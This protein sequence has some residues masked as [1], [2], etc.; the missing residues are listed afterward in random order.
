MTFINT[1]YELLFEFLMWNVIVI[2]SYPLHIIVSYECKC[3]LYKCSNHVHHK[4]RYN[5]I[6]MYMNFC[7][8]FDNCIFV[9]KIHKM[10]DTWARMNQQPPVHQLAVLSIGWAIFSH[11]VS[12]GIHHNPFF[13]TINHCIYLFMFLVL[14]H[15]SPRPDLTHSY[16]T[17]LPTFISTTP[18]L[19]PYLLPHTNITTL[20]TSYL[21]NLAT[22]LTTSLID[23]TTILITYPINSTIVL[24][25]L[26]M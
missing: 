23:L 24:T 12:N 17:H 2:Y 14:G 22:I 5:N 7:I 11:L 4:L 20:I 25:T 15:F 1:W 18:T 6:L 21:I 3:V 19:V 9:F 10:H 8:S 26:L 13:F 16:F